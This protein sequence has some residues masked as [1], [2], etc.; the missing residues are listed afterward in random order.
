MIHVTCAI[1][2]N[3]REDVFVAQRSSAM[4]LPL[5]WEFPGGKVEDDM[6][7]TL[8]YALAHSFGSMYQIPGA[9]IYFSTIC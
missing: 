7:Q 9:F 2:L 6:A 8:F 4:H 5:Q 1:I 3:E